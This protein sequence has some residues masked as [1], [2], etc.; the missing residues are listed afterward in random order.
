MPLSELV[1]GLIRG[2]CGLGSPQQKVAVRHLEVQ[3]LPIELG[4]PLRR[5]HADAA[6]KALRVRGDGPGQ[7]QAAARG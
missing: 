3:P 5:L 1:D 2:M 6:G 4:R 7:V